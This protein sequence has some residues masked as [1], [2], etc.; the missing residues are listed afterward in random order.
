MKYKIEEV[1]SFNTATISKHHEGP[2]KYMDTSSVNINKFDEPEK[3]SSLDEA[4]SRARRM[5]ER[6]DIV[7]STVRPNKCHYG[8][9]DKKNSNYVYS[10]GFVVIHPDI[11]KVD[12]YYL[13]LVLSSNNIIAKLQKIAEGSTSTYPSFKP[14]DLMEMEF[15]FPT[16]EIQHKISLKIRAFDNKIRINELINDNLQAMIRLIADNLFSYLN[17]NNKF[18]MESWKLTKLADISDFNNGYSYKGKELSH[19]SI[20]M[21]T[22]K[23]FNRDG[24]FKIKGFKEIV[25]SKDIKPTQ[26]VKPLDI[27]VAH[28]DLTQNADI[29][30]NAMPVLSTG[31]F[32]NTIFSMDLV[33][34]KPKRGYPSS[35]ISALL[36][37]KRFKQFCLG[38]VN[39]TTV[40]HLSK[41]ALNNY[42][43]P[44]PTNINELNRLDKLFSSLYSQMCNCTRENEI[45]IEIKEQLIR[46]LFLNTLN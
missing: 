39:G 46:N 9:I 14:N 7:I 12:P 17:K 36:Q 38:Y 32:S 11:N 27:L 20:G 6:N 21:A 41:K 1:S 22:I 16:I 2:I 35:V 28:T 34:V 10:T 25:P 19:S 43:T 15:N 4:P 44:F 45:L 30:G 13:Y 23:N 5:A 3:Y 40:L 33:K 18:N 37:T 24:S 42:S 29:I 31:K 8:F 26:I